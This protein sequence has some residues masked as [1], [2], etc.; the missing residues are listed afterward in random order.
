MGVV[1]FAVDMSYDNSSSSNAVYPLSIPDSLA[2]IGS[3]YVNLSFRYV[4]NDT[5][6]D[7]SDLIDTM[8]F[9]CCDDIYIVTSNEHISEIADKAFLINLFAF[10]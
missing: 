9:T 8:G 3:Q 7:I 2:N 4:T 6:P 1:A 10:L 5:A